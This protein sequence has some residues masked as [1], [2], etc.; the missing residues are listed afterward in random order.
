MARKLI[1]NPDQTKIWYKDNH[2]H[3]EILP[4]VIYP[5]GDKKW[6]LCN[7]KHR[8][9]DLPAVEYTNGTKIWFC[10]GL[11]HREDG[12]AVIYSNGDKEW[13]ENGRLI[14]WEKFKS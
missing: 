11:L 1:I 8:E 2:I 13:H 14:L 5:N 6:F 4:A 7:L 10:S 3:R 9:C 12:P